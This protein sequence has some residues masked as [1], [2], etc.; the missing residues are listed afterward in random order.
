MM[1]TEI[2]GN[3]HSNALIYNL[4][5]IATDPEPILRGKNGPFFYS[6]FRNPRHAVQKPTVILEAFLES[7]KENSCP[8]QHREWNL[9][10]TNYILP[11]N[12]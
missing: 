4:A 6:T 12:F 8:T 9:N 7:E 1:K 5:S 11:Q 2:T 3:L 10:R